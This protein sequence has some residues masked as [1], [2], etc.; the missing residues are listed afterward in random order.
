VSHHVMNS[1]VQPTPAPLR[2]CGKCCRALPVD[3]FRRRSKSS[4]SRSSDCRACHN[5]YEHARI[6]KQRNQVRRRI[7]RKA[8]DDVSRCRTIEE[9]AAVIRM[10]P[11]AFGGAEKLYQF[12]ID[13]V[14]R[15]GR[16]GEL[17]KFCQLWFEFEKLQYV[18]QVQRSNR[19]GTPEYAAEMRKDLHELV[20]NNPEIVA[21]AHQRISGTA[22]WSGAGPKTSDF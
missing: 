19:L 12:W 9:A 21:E 1:P 13:Q 2:L 18:A 16:P 3:E 7:V 14:R 11:A 6:Q 17:I 5:H 4:E 15:G 8:A 10:I 22:A 20:R